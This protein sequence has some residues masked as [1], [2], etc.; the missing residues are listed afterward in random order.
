MAATPDN[1][2]GAYIP[3]TSDELVIS[4]DSVTSPMWSN[5]APTLRAYVTSSAQV[6]SAA[7]PYYISIYQ[8]SSTDPTAEIQFDTV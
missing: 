7:A 5:N 6:A 4:T 1:N 3:L 8:T 2:R